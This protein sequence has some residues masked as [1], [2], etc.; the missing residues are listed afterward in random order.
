MIKLFRKSKQKM[1][2]D[3]KFSNYF[4]YAVGEIILVVIGILIAVG[5]NSLYNNYENEEKIKTILTQ[6]QQDLETDI[7]D[8]KRIF[9]VLIEKDSLFQKII[10][11]SITFEMYKKNPY[12]LPINRNYVSFSNNKG[13]YNRLL[14]NLEILPE[15]YRS[16]LP[17]LNYLYV[18]IQNEI[19]DYNTRIKQ[20]VNDA[21]DQMFNSNPKVADYFLGR[22]RNEALEFYFKDPFL[23]N[24]SAMYMNDLANISGTANDY[25][26]ESIKLYKKIDSLLGKTPIAYAEP[27]LILPKKEYINSFLGNYK[28]INEFSEDSLTVSIENEQLVVKRT[29]GSEFKLYWHEDNYYYIKGVAIFRLYKNKQGQD[30]I[31]VSYLGKKFTYIKT[32]DL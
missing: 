26:I 18:E 28:G 29:G 16:L 4:L 15:K 5:I 25:Q 31:E 7:K 17:D 19:D 3:N 11:D 27:F 32:E 6:V 13:G 21:G 1:L 23:K 2:N 14:N 20:I 9:N 30:V 12:P 10:N 24:H 22:Y 8:A